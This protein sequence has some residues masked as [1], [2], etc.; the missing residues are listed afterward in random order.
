MTLTPQLH[1]PAQ[2]PLLQWF[3]P[4][5]PR[6]LLPRFK[7]AISDSS[8][9]ASP[10]RS[11]VSLASGRGGAFPCL[12]ATLSLCHFPPSRG[13][14]LQ[15]SSPLDILPSPRPVGAVLAFPSSPRL[16]SSCRHP[17][18][19]VSVVA[20]FGGFPCTP[21][22]VLPAGPW[23]GTAGALAFCAGPFAARLTA[24]A[25]PFGISSSDARPHTFQHCSAFL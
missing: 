13:L 23:C 16:P 12:G 18:A 11:P 20:V 7:R 9:C 15:L 10:S 14:W 4:A 21:S 19:S 5:T 1:L 22:R 6:R 17:T 3:R 25:R 8:S 24:V 2:Q